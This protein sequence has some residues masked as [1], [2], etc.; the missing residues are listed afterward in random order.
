MYSLFGKG[1]WFE[2]L[3]EIG[4]FRR[5]LGVRGERCYKKHWEV[6]EKFIMGSKIGSIWIAL[7][8]IIYGDVETQ[9]QEGEPERLK[10]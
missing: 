9:E 6:V 10:F 3:N 5:F 8:N 2:K 1:W 4:E 7:N